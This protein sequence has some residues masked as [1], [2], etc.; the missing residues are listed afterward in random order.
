ME[1]NLARERERASGLGGQLKQAK[2]ALTKSESRAEA[3]TKQ[4]RELE[5]K[6]AALEKERSALTATVQKQRQALEAAKEGPKKGPE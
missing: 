5:R 3:L 2:D 1:K 4:V 6:A